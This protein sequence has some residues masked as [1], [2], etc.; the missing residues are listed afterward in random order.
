MPS[1]TGKGSF[2]HQLAL[3]DTSTSIYGEALW[4]PGTMCLRRSS[5]AIFHC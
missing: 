2:R 3:F 1:H 5:I 4:R